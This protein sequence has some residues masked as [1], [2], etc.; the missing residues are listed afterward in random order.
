MTSALLIDTTD[1]LEQTIETV[2]TDILGFSC[3]CVEAADTETAIAQVLELILA[4]DQ[5]NDWKRATLLSL[6]KQ[7]REA[8][9]S[10]AE[11]DADQAEIAR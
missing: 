3:G 7:F 11:Y 9:V 4:S 1:T 5:T 6:L 8:T 2:E 10:R